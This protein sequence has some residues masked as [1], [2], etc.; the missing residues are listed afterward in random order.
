MAS[1][2]FETLQGGILMMTIEGEVGGLDNPLFSAMSNLSKQHHHVLLNLSNLKT[3]GKKF[4][5]LLTDL[6]ARTKMKIIATEQEIVKE[7]TA[8]GFPT[9][10]SQKSASLSYAGDETI[11]LLLSRLRD[12]PIMNTEAY[13]LIYYMTRPEATFA[14]LEEMIRDNSGLC[15]QIFRIANSSYFHRVTRAETLSQAMVT[16]GFT[17]LR[18]LFTYN[19]YTSVGG[20]FKS[21]A[22]S[23]NH[24]RKC[25]LL[26]EF[27]CKG[28]EAPPE[29]CTRVR[30]AGLMHDVGKMALAFFFPHQYEKVTEMVEREGKPYY[31]CELMVF[32]TEHQAVGSLLANR[33]NFPTYLSNIIGDHHFL[34]G[35]KWNVMTLPI[36]VASNFLDEKEGKPFEPYYHRLE[37]YFFLK[38]KEL[39]WENVEADFE[40]H[41]AEH[42]D[43]FV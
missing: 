10:P 32:G 25:A 12:V 6:S 35:D 5:E 11:N 23:I 33:W 7:C 29:E 4:Y 8:A 2:R 39:P 34:Q 42:E 43:I 22:H 21:Q 37:G 38:K 3:A 20:L 14:K 24:G 1:Y 28:A 16:L 18:Q 26:A 19:F 17:N 40:K 15:S 9:F 27:I 36:F 13:N 31:F 30:L 41:L